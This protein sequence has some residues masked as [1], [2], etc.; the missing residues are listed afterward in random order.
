MKLWDTGRN[1]RVGRIQR[2]PKLRAH[3]LWSIFLPQ[4]WTVL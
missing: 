3:D 2:T 4:Q 1:M